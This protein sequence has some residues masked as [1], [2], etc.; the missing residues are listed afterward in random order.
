MKTIEA[1]PV[2]FKSPLQVFEFTLDHEKKVT[3][4]I[5][6]LYEL[7][8]KEKNYAFQSFLKWYIDEQVEE[9][10]SAQEIIDKIKLAGESGPGLFM[11]DKEMAGRIC[12]PPTKDE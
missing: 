11:L 3:G 2:T 12:T 6:K 9:E 8:M 4:L 7:A 5:N 1:P 10:A